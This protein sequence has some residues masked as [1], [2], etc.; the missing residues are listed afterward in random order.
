MM[1]FTPAQANAIL[2]DQD[3]NDYVNPGAYFCFSQT[4]S[5]IANCPVNKA[6]R[7]DVIDIKPRV[8][9]KYKYAHQIIRTISSPESEYRRSI[10]K[11]SLSAEDPWTFSQWYL[12]E[13]T[14]VSQ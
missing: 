14:A 8:S 4:Y 5:S 10:Q 9:T 13:G 12:I 2:N 6:F 1:P 7:M 11:T 3:L